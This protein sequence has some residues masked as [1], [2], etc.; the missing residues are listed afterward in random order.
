MTDKHDTATCPCATCAAL[1]AAGAGGYWDD[2][3]AWDRYKPPS[4][5][6][7]PSTEPPPPPPPKD[8]KK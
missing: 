7:G 6:G 2:T 5:G 8:G 3:I 4:P 1:R